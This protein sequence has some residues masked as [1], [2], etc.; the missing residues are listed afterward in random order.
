MSGEFEAGTFTG[1]SC[2]MCEGAGWI[3]AWV[4]RDYYEI[5]KCD[6]CEEFRSDASAWSAL[7]A[8]LDS[9]LAGERANPTT[10]THLKGL[11]DVVRQFRPN[12]RRRKKE[13]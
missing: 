4:D 13:V 6:T 1:S 3:L 7:K 2:E 11:M 10:E 12:R 5:E 9:L 8:S